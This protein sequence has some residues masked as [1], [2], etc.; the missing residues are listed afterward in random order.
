ISGI[1]M[2]PF[3]ATFIG[4]ENSN[5]TMN[6]VMRIWK[7]DV[8]VPTRCAALINHHF[9]K[10]S[11]QPGEA[12][13]FRGGGAFIGVVRMAYSLTTMTE[14]EATLFGITD[15]VDRAALFRLDDAKL[16][17]AA[18]GRER[19]YRIVAVKLG[20]KDISSLYPEGDTVHTIEPWTPPD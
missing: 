12:D 10:G 15:P 2:D 5:E 8:A 14:K 19:W 13:A 18:A 1:V 11:A 20:N 16:N 4:A 3:A 7:D 6:R 9:R 17:M